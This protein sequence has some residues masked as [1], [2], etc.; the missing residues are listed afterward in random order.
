MFGPNLAA[1]Q[2]AT[3]AENAVKFKLKLSKKWKRKPKKKTRWVWSGKQNVGSFIPIFH[4][5]AV[6]LQIFS[7]L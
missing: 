6:F 1:C 2:L 4:D 7:K 3:W 5:F